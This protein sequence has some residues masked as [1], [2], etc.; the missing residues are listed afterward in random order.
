MPLLPSVIPVLDPLANQLHAEPGRIQ[1]YH[2][3]YVPPARI[4]DLYPS[5]LP[6]GLVL[7][8]CRILAQ[9]QD[10]YLT[11]YE[12]ERTV[13][14]SE[15]VAALLPPHKYKFHV[16]SD[17]G[18]AICTKFR[19]WI[20]PA[21]LPQAWGEMILPTDTWKDP[22]DNWTTL[23]FKLKDTDTQCAVTGAISRLHP[24]HLVPKAEALWLDAAAGDAINSIDS[25]RNIITLRADLN[26]D[27]FDQGHFVIVP[28]ASHPVAC[29]ITLGCGDPAHNHHMHR[30]QLPG[31]IRRHYLYARFVWNLFKGFREHFA[32]LPNYIKKVPAVNFSG[33]G[34]GKGKGN[35]DRAQDS[36]PG[37][38][39]ID[40]DE[41]EELKAGRGRRETRRLRRGRR[42]AAWPSEAVIDS[43]GASLDIS[44]STHFDHPHQAR[45]PRGPRR[46]PR[47]PAGPADRER[48][49][50]G[51]VPRL[52]QGAAPGAGV[53]GGAPRGVGGAR[54][55]GC[56]GR[57]ARF[58]WG[59]VG[60]MGEDAF[61]IQCRHGDSCVY[62]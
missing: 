18:Y 39:E 56:A 54:G 16:P 44:S 10:G 51:L 8:A 46:L 14:S 47:G 17:P 33:S 45:L 27:T 43:E 24:S 31:R 5:R 1:V 61:H 30:V 34:K 6:L 58:G 15:D 3:S 19:N 38:G 21:R 55:A 52:Q 11:P 9:N 23:S 2:P 53:Q 26:A 4:L 48:R 60:C 42:R 50:A 7:D 28:Y 32:A 57:G 25:A 59:G 20:P 37:T 36:Y 13:I 40:A 12:A 41:G 49:R 22:H 35:G 29:F 62:S